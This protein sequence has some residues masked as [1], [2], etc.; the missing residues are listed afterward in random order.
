MV[1]AH[2]ALLLLLLTLMVADPSSSASAADHETIREHIAR[3]LALKDSKS[4]DNS[5]G[6]FRKVL[7]MRSD[8]DH[9]TWAE[10]TDGMNALCHGQYA[11]WL[12]DDCPLRSCPIK[13]LALSTLNS[14]LCSCCRRCAALRASGFT[15]PRD[16]DQFYKWDEP[17]K[18]PPPPPPPPPIHEAFAGLKGTSW[19]WNNWRDV[20]FACDGSFKAPTPDCGVAGRCYWWADADNLYIQWGDAGRHTAPKPQGQTANSKDWRHLSGR[21]DRDADPFSATW[22]NADE[23]PEDWYAVLG[24]DSTATATQIKKA[25]RSLSVS[26]HPDKPGGDASAFARAG[27]A[28]EILSNPDK[29][30]VYDKEAGYRQDAKLYAEE[31]SVVNTMDAKQ[32]K[33]KDPSAIHIVDFYAPWCGHCQE[34]APHFRRAALA[35]EN[36]ETTGGDGGNK[37]VQFHAVDCDEQKSLCQ[38]VGI[39]GYPSVRLFR[40]SD[41]YEEIYNGEHTSEALEQ[42]VHS[43]QNS[44]VARLSSSE[45]ATKVQS[46]SKDLG[47]VW[48]VDF[49]A[50]SWCGP[51]TMLQPALRQAAEEL[52]G[53]ASVAI[54]DCDRYRVLCEA[55]GVTAYPALRYYT[56]YGPRNGQSI[57]SQSSG[58]VDHSTMLT[59]WAQGL[60]VGLKSRDA[61]LLPSGSYKSKT[62]L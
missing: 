44:K 2:C 9:A 29:R 58:R 55:Q 62:D 32:F 11:C 46:K 24:V 56:P 13:H 18:P 20:T 39:N 47:T 43:V 19:F 16:I 7:T 27:T 54:V 25:F 35:F 30:S 41:D 52:D 21:R 42:W 61:D 4:W 60:A 33:S 57:G 51:C 40:P 34:L 3:A 59:L 28:Y 5:I 8:A 22:R 10:A 6:E 45:F 38:H 12:P 36:Q 15:P 17:P 23:C 14:R 26:L 48:V 37:V 31:A 1:W 49:S 53:V 50:G